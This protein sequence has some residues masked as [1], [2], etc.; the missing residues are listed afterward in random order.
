M[1]LVSFIAGFRPTAN[2]VEWIFVLALA[3]FFSLSIS[4]LSA[5]LG[6][7]VKTIEAAQWM[8]FVVIFPLT[9]A[10]SAFA[11]TETMPG[12][13]RAFAEN[14][15]LTHVV[16]AM[17]AWLVGTPVGNSATLAFIWTFGI[18]VVSLPLAAW[19]FRRYSK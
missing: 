8:G 18:I 4:W 12:V 17:R 11:P 7:F 2:P 14:Q 13:L 19:L 1:L 6:L 15:P 5:I 3:I 16:N 9:F 10:S